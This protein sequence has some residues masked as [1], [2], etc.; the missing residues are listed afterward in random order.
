MMEEEQVLPAAHLEQ[1]AAMEKMLHHAVKDVPWYEGQ[2]EIGVGAL[3]GSPAYLASGTTGDFAYM[4]G[5][6]YPFIWETYR[7]DEFRQARAR[8]SSRR[9]DAVQCRRATATSA[10]ARAGRR[11]SSRRS[12][13]PPRRSRFIPPPWACRPPTRRPSS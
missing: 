6:K 1:Q 4:A 10:E 2:P 13:S 5:V 8:H 12:P 7:L 9:M 11:S 3:T